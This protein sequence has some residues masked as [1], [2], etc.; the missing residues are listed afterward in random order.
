MKKGLCIVTILFLSIHVF[1]QEAQW[2][3]PDRSGKYPETG[4]L[5]EWSEDGPEMMLKVEGIGVGYSTPVLNE[6]IFYVT[7]KK[8]EDD[9][10]SAIDLNGELLYQ[11]T[12]GKSWTNTYPDT[13]STPTIEDDRIYLVSGIGEVVCLNRL[14][15][16]IIWSINA[17]EKYEG[18]VHRWGIAESPLIIDDK[19]L[20]TSGGEQTSVIAFD[21]ITGE[22]VW[23]TESI[24]GSRTYVS[25]VIYQNDSVRLILASTSDYVIGIE[26]ETGELAWKYRYR[27]DD[28][29]NK[30]TTISTNSAIIKG[31]E[32]FI[33]KGYNSYGVM[34]Q[35]ADDGK[36]INEKWRTDVMD[37]HHG[38]YVNVGDYI[39]G[40]NWESNSKGNWV[41]LEWDTG[42]VMYEE[43]W[44]TKGPIAF[45]DSKLYCYEERQ[46][47]FAL[48][49][50][51]PEKFDIVST[52]KIEYGS[53][54]HWA[55][56]YI[57]DGKMLIRHGDVL[58]VFNIKA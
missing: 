29:D 54:P 45:A 50:P 24:G 39:Y 7:G 21:K 8:D 53:G 14:N 11:V 27:L 58:M 20:Y 13:R 23:T 41:C 6:G 32:I 1:A 34:L 25:P 42:K 43:K 17:N 49:N 56:P 48:V 55:H 2:R 10:L 16:E 12:Y 15:G 35:M 31:N 52:F 38:Q 9:Y 22:E 5:Q 57:I 44:H 26:P 37:T 51:T 19:V 30:G 36:S 40:S 18:K 47:N 28:P 4:L 46:G 33:S 3:G